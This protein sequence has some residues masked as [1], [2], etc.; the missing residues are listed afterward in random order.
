MKNRGS[1]SRKQFLK[2]STAMVVAGVLG[3]FSGDVYAE[4]KPQGEIRHVVSAL[5]SEWEPLPLDILSGACLISAQ[6][7]SLFGGTV[8]NANCLL[9]QYI[10]VYPGLELLLSNI[11]AA[12]EESTW[13][14]YNKQLLPIAVLYSRTKNDGAETRA[15][16]TIPADIYYLRGSFSDASG[17]PRVWVKNF[18]Q[19]ALNCRLCKP[20]LIDYIEITELT[21]NQNMRRDSDG[22][23]D[24]NANQMPSMGDLFF[25]PIGTDII[26]TFN[27]ACI[28]PYIQCGDN[29]MLLKQKRIF[30][31]HYGFGYSWYHCKTKEICNC[32]GAYYETSTGCARKLTL[33]ELQAAEPHLYI[34]FPGKT[35]N[36]QWAAKIRTIGVQKRHQRLFTVVHLTDTHGDADSTYAAYKYAD[37]IGTDFVALTGDYVPYSPY[38]GYNILHSIIKEAKTPTVYTIGNHDVVGLSD[39]NIYST[40]Y[41]P[42]K[43]AIHASEDHPYYYR[44]FQYGTEVVRAISLCPFSG[45][46]ASHVYGYYSQEQ[47]LWLCDALA[48]APDGSHVFIL[49]HFAHRKPVIPNNGQSMFYDYADNEVDTGYSWLNMRVDPVTAIVDAYNKRETIFSQYTGDLKDGIETI[50]VRYNF[51]NRTDSE[52]VAYFTGHVHIDHIGYARDTKTKQAVLGSLCTVG[53]KG[54]E[55][56]SSYTSLSSPRDYGTDSQIAFNVFTFDFNKKKIYTARVGNALFNEHEKTWMELSYS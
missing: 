21:L 32:L 3:R 55:E 4:E 2:S 46:A 56:Y 31:Q 27:N 53:A 43:D 9:T 39:Q 44:D 1:F 14:G 16:V 6:K 45:R 24:K 41:A 20:D 5:E 18:A 12:S 47:L 51:K 49:R 8:E 11:N 40:C 17:V 42:I 50:T 28:A 30:S 25:T 36:T 48:T 33:E 26:V 54:S 13:I 52:F 38:H 23:F 7:A 35:V 10:H 34:R 19:Y 37:Q 29:Y 15:L 22:K